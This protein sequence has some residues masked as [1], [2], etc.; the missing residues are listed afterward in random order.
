[1]G[2]KNGYI[3]IEIKG[4]FAICHFHP[5]AEGGKPMDYSDIIEYLNKHEIHTDDMAGL[6]EKLVSGE[7]AEMFM[8]PYKG[9]D[10]P[11]SMT[12]KISLDRMKVTCTF[13]P[14]SVNGRLLNAKD[15]LEELK[16]KGIV[17]GINQDEIMRY[18]EEREYNQPYIFAKGEPTIMGHDGKIEYMFNTNPSLR[19]KHNEDGS[20][21][22]KELST[23]NPVAKDQLIAKLTP[24]DPGKAGK[25][26][27]GKDMPLLRV[28]MKKL[29]FG[30]N[31]YLSD[32]RTELYSAVTGHVSL[33]DGQVFVSDVFEV[34]GDVDNST[35]NIKY[36]GGIHIHGSVRGGF[37]VIA[38]GDVV[39]D[40]VVE[41]AM[42]RSGGQIIIKRGVHGMHKGVLEAKGNV[43]SAFIENAKVVSGGYVETGSIIYSDVRASEDVI[44]M[45]KKGF[46]AGGIVCAGGKVE[47]MTIGSSMG[48]VTRLEVG[49][50]PEKKERFGQLQKLIKNLSM[51]VDK[52]EPVVR[53]YNEYINSGKKL[54][55][56]N[57]GYLTQV[58]KELSA[59]KK[60]LEEC[61][62]EYNSLH[63]ELLMSQHSKVVIKRDIYPSVTVV[64][65]DQSMTTKEKRSYCVFEKRDSEIKVSNL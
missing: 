16:K 6:R 10:F 5:P 64:I 13:M 1:M 63:Q 54:D 61:R 25:D 51:R 42:V 47:A 45:Q 3:Q 53:T 19:P 38:K 48:A 21:D 18:L 49:M 17:F 20:V 60:D 12:I 65:S 57:E 8:G 36:E 41:D 32:D 56:K 28:K 58:L 39:I 11:E 33:I 46:I 43:M 62:L 2:Q 52:L 29:E 59:S 23:I 15:I 4:G 50:A 55:E 14:P 27:F 44:V 22:F 31:M 30:K 35:G 7:P 37:T 24:A 34:Q 9:Y 26:V 40:G